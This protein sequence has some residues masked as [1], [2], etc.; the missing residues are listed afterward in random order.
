M[1]VSVPEQSSLPGMEA[2]VK[3]TDRLFFAI[4]PDAD[5]AAH[6]VRTALALR[7]RL[8]LTGKVLLP[9]RFHVTLHHVGDHAG[10]PP[11]LVARAIEAGGLTRLPAFP[12]SFDR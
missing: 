5:T 12:L 6:I 8:G 1:G 4:F 9:Q 10:L 7:S 11:Q 2:E 3:T